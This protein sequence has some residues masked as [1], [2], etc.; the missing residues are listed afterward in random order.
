MV[1]ALVCMAACLWVLPAA[2]QAATDDALQAAMRQGSLAMTAGEFEKAVDAFTIVTKSRP[3]LAEG[4]FNLGLALEQLGKLD[5]ARTELESALK[6]KPELRGANLFLGLIAYRQNHYK[7]AERYLTHETHLDPTNAKAFLWLGVCHLAEDDA[8]GAIALLDKAYELDPKD[9]DI[10]Y[11]RGRAYLLVANASYDAM[12][13]L[14]HDSMRVHQVL[15]EAYA[16]SY[17]TP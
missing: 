7:D 17:R 6:Q 15:G 4:H 5:E 8:Q 10:L 11:H 16:Q 3:G 2:G 9:A 12:F 13:K 14:D 1:S